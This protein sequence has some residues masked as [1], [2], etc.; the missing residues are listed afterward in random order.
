MLP[1]PVAIAD[2]AAPI[3]HHVRITHHAPRIAHGMVGGG[4]MHGLHVV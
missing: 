2:H 3:T 4:M 1:S